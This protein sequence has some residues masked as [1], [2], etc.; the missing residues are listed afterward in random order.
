LNDG[1]NSNARS[2]DPSAETSWRPVFR[3]IAAVIAGVLLSALPAVATDLLMRAIGQLPAL[4]ERPADGPL[5]FAT[6]YRTIYSIAGSYVTA[7]LAP[8]RPMTHAMILGA[9]GLLVT[10]AG[11]IA[12]WNAGP[13]FEPKWYPLA[14]IALAL[15]SAWIGGKIY[16]KHRPG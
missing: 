10:T 8:K 2:V 7:R 11:A 15:P 12:T 9:L 13:A 1:N 14:L 6:I 5:L 4:D 16:T 3:S